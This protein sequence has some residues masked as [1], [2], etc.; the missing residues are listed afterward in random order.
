LFNRKLSRIRSLEDSI[1]VRGCTTV[2]VGDWRHSRPMHLLLLLGQR[3][4]SRLTHCCFDVLTPMS[5]H[6]LAVSAGR[7]DAGEN[8]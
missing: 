7:D 8:A 4:W 6:E 1:S 2:D 3:K 5:V